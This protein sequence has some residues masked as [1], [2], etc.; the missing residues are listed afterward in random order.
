MNNFAPDA[1]LN[2]FSFKLQALEEYLLASGWS[3]GARGWRWPEYLNEII[4]IC[5]YGKGEYQTSLAV[6]VQAQFDEFRAGQGH[7]GDTH[8]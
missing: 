7:W 4:W 6:F 2:L 8:E 1:R 3:K 5:P